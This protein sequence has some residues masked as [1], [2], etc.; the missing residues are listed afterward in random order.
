MWSVS[1][2]ELLMKTSETHVNK[3]HIEESFA[4]EDQPVH[5]LKCN[6]LKNEQ[7][8]IIQSYDPDN[9][10]VGYDLYADFLAFFVQL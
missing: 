7:K 8:E 5:F 2:L 6:H 4:P 9:F 10:S 3:S 1:I